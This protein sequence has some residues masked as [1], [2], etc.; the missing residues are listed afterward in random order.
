MQLGIE[1]H[2]DG[3]RRVG[4]SIT[5]RHRQESGG[6]PAAEKPRHRRDSATFTAS[7][8]LLTLF[9]EAMFCQRVRAAAAR[10]FPNPGSTSR[11]NLAARSAGDSGFSSCPGAFTMRTTSV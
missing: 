6:T 1:P 7:K 11:V 4:R 10:S 5:H 9:A 2:N 3:V 8:A